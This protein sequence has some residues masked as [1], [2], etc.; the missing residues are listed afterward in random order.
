MNTSDPYKI[1]GV[2]PDATEKEIKKA[3]RELAKKYHPD[4]YADDPLS[5]LAREKMLEINNAYD[6]VIRMRREGAS[7]QPGDYGSGYSSY[8]YGSS[9]QFADIRRLIIQNRLSEAEELLEGVPSAS[10]DAEWHFLKGS[11]LYRKGWLNGAREHFTAAYNMDPGNAEYREAYNRMMYQ[12]RSARAY[13]YNPGAG[14]RT[15]GSDC[16]ACDMC[17]GL[18]CADCCCE[19]MGG[20]LIR[21][22]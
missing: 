13:G 5:D 20:D 19:C 12:T 22:C 14:Y 15:G 8:G 11:V 10:R 6:E 9:S 2:S 7:G 17:T 3:Y 1:L 4:N 16:S 21:C 18:I